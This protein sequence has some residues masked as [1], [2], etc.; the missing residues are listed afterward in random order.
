MVLKQVH[1]GKNGGMWEGISVKLRE[2]GE[3]ELCERKV[4]CCVYDICIIIINL[5]RSL[6]SI[7][8]RVLL[9]S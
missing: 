1:L 6:I 9:L 3:F 4:Y 2:F 8:L 7:S 5:R